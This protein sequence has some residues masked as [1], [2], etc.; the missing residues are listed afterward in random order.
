MCS[1]KVKQEIELVKME[2][3]AL[4]G[5]IRNKVDETQDQAGNLF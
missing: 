3:V 5:N 1:R 4:V 2:K